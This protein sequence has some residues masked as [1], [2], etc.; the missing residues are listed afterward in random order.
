MTKGDNMA[1]FKNAK[2]KG[3]GKGDIII[4]AGLTVALTALIGYSIFKPQERL[5]VDGWVSRQATKGC[6]TLYCM[7][8]EEKKANNVEGDTFELID[9]AIERNNVNPRHI[10]LGRE[11][12]IPSETSTIEVP[13]KTVCEDRRT[14]GKFKESTL[15]CIILEYFK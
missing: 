11:Y 6:P 5:V 13:L 7:V 2:T 1:Y 4:G 12:E 3:I 15:G 14:D 9:K 10:Q 8:R